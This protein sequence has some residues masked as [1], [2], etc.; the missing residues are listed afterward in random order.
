MQ[1]KNFKN[2]R[3]GILI[4]G[5]IILFSCSG[6]NEAD[7]KVK[8]DKELASCCQKVPSRFPSDIAKKQHKGMVFIPGG[9]FMMGGDNEQARKDEYPKHKVE[10][11]GF[12]MDVHEVTNAQFKEFVDATGYL[13]VAERKPIWEE[14]KKQLPPGTPKPDESLFV[15]ASLVFTPPA[16]PVNVNVNVNVAPVWWS[17]VKGANWRQP[18]GPSSDLIGLENHP[19]VH[20]AWEDAMAYC[21]WAGKRLPTEA[22]WE[23]AARGGLSNKIY[24]WGNENVDEGSVKAN[25]WQG[26]FPNHNTQRD[27]FYATSPVK[28][29]QANYFGL[30]DMAGNVWEW[31]SD[32]YHADYYKSLNGIV[33]RNP[34][35][36]LSSYDP[37]EPNIPKRVV[38][39]GSFLCNEDYCSGYRVAARMKTSIDTG[40]SHTGFRCVQDEDNLK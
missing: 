8:E 27:A 36:P 14:M 13:T 5:P 6:K 9:S 37:Q 34:Q 23:Y 22:E 31:C 16:Y 10:L 38:R 4:L 33:V 19:V 7:K 21:K 2:I 39:G 28:S 11:S 15:P 20:V 30:Y 1:R 32:W 18:K 17:W 40:L 3:I 12:W 35:G 24:P 25:S 29:F 26:Q